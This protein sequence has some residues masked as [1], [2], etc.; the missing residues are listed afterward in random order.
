MLLIRERRLPTPGGPLSGYDCGLLL[1][2][3]VGG[4]F[5]FELGWSRWRS[6][7]EVASPFPRT[8]SPDDM[9][10]G[11][12]GVLR[13][14][15]LLEEDKGPSGIRLSPSYV[16]MRKIFEIWRYPRTLSKERRRVFASLSTNSSRSFL[17]LSES[18]LRSCPSF[19]SSLRLRSSPRCFSRE[20]RLELRSG[21]WNLISGSN[22]LCV[23]FNSLHHQEPVS[24]F[25]GHPRRL[26]G[27]GADWDQVEWGGCDH[28]GG[29]EACQAAND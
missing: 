9:A 10:R 17:R 28:P 27:F 18:L 7:P 1:P 8:T 6:R 20:L 25:Q 16:G 21:L 26:G 22:R 11:A 15:T 2:E 19:S 4:P 29:L 12:D 5:E 3:L 14:R 24:A 23:N 13:G